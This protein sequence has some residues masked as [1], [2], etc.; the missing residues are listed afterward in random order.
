M[1]R[2]IKRNI[3]PAVIAATLLSVGVSVAVPGTAAAFL[4]PGIST[5]YPSDG[6]KWEYG[7]SNAKVRSYYTANGC[8]GST[9]IY[10]GATVRSANTASGYRSMADKYAINTPGAD[11]A[12]YYRSC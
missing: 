1:I 2:Q 4:H 5:Q 8:H 7:F 12:Y 10:N 9:V 6:G 11:D 3:G